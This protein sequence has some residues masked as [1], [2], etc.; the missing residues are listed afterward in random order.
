VVDRKNLSDHETLIRRICATPQN[1]FAEFTEE[2]LLYLRAS[3]RRKVFNWES[4]VT[5]IQMTETDRQNLA[6]VAIFPC[7][8][9]MLLG[10]IGSA[11]PVQPATQVPATQA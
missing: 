3:S 1:Q 11:D 5:N 7:P 9:Y 4:F 2:K 8:Q 6:K 10:D